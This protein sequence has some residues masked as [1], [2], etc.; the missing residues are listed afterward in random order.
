MSGCM[1]TPINRVIFNRSLKTFFY[2]LGKG[3]NN[4]PEKSE[5]CRYNGRELRTKKQAKM[6]EI[7]IGITY[8]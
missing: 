6:C 1:S 4:K 2:L 5:R 7:D 3:V 8:Q